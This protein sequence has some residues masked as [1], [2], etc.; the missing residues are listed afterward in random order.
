MSVLSVIPPAVDV[1]VCPV[2]I[3]NMFELTVF[4]FWL[5]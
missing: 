2:C 3:I 5:E 4:R 1:K